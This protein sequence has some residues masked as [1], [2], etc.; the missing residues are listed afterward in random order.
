MSHKTLTNTKPQC[1]SHLSMSLSR[2]SLSTNTSA[3]RRTYLSFARFLTLYL[4]AQQQTHHL[5]NHNTMCIGPGRFRCLNQ[6]FSSVSPAAFILFIVDV[7]QPYSNQNVPRSSTSF[8]ALL[9]R[10]LLYSRLR[11]NIKI[12]SR[13]CKVI[14]I[15]FLR[16]G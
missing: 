6:D 2:F 14:C 16:Y 8:Y 10:S 12:I 15:P 1:L 3:L 4:P 5:N 9:H 7:L 11:M 13:H